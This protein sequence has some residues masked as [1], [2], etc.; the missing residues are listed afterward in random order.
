[1]EC[2][3]GAL[4]A[5]AQGFKVFPLVENGK[6]PAIKDWQEWAENSTVDKVTEFSSARPNCNWG[7]YCG[8]SGL[9]VIDVDTKEGKVGLQ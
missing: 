4:W 6:L 9:T 1:L 3:Q 5:I 2:K 8:A 7:L